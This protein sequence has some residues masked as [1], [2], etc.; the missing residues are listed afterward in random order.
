MV[1]SSFLEGFGG[2]VPQISVMT[3]VEVWEGCQANRSLCGGEK[4]RVALGDG[5][6]T[7]LVLGESFGC[8]P[9]KVPI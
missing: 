6:T 8:K 1:K 7:G 2:P 5:A 4:L 3:D 9:G